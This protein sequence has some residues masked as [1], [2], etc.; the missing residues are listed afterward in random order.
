MEKLNLP[1]FPFRIRSSAGGNEIFD[2]I[3]KKFIRLTPEEWVRQHLLQY[4][5]LQLKYPAALISVEAGTSY[6]QLQKRTDI[7]VHDRQG[8]PWM[9]IECKKPQLKIT[10]RVF[11]QASVYNKALPA[12]VPYLAVSNGLQHFCCEFYPN[13]RKYRFRDDFPEYT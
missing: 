12:P 6:N 5:I 2:E 3:R 11:D 10:A 1:D 4:L 8:K 13:E 7:V 9:I